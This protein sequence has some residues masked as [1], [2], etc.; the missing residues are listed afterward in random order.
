MPDSAPDVLRGVAPNS[1][2]TFAASRRI[3]QATKAFGFVVCFASLRFWLT[4]CRNR[5]ELFLRRLDGC[6]SN[7]ISPTRR[8]IPK[9][10]RRAF[11]PIV[12]RAN[13]SG[14]RRIAAKPCICLCLENV[15]VMKS[16]K[17]LVGIVACRFGNLLPFGVQDKTNARR[18]SSGAF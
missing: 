4:R 6:S 16:Q 2:L 13:I 1:N 5:A 9:F 17:I 7:N 18:F 11:F 3:C 8:S 14:L 15:V 12:C 10:P